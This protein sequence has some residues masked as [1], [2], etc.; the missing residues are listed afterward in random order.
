MALNYTD[1]YVHI[2]KKNGVEYNV[3]DA[4]AAAAIET[5]QGDVNTEGSI[6]KAAKDAADD[7][8]TYSKGLIDKVLGADSAANTITSLQNVLNELNDPDNQQGITGTFV[9]T[10]KAGLAGL[11]KDDGNGG[12]T[13]VT[14]K[15]Y[16]DNAVANASSGAATAI[17]ALDAEKTSSDANNVQVTVTEVDGV[18]TAVNV[19]D[20]SINA[21]DLSNKVGDLGNTEAEYYTQQEIDAAQPGDEAYGKTTADIK[22]A[23]AAHTVKSYVDTKFSNSAF[24]IK[25]H[26]L[27]LG[28]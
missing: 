12:T 10:V 25:D 13:S 20:N 8:K 28:L 24:T 4:L 22:T 11:T 15:E 7:A 18:I 21:T 19:T 16:V 26:V 9:D 27:E 17:A 6:L 1:N 23:A 5:I 3:K 2:I 14:V